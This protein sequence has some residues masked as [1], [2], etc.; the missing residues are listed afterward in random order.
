[1]F[2]LILY[3][4][5]FFATG[6]GWKP[7]PDQPPPSPRTPATAARTFVLVVLLALAGGWVLAP[8]RAGALPLLSHHGRWLTDP[9]GRVVILHGLQVDRFEPRAPIEFIDMSPANVRFLGAMGFNVARVSLAYAGYAPKPGQFD[10]D[11]LNSYLRFDRLLAGAGVY[12]LVDMMQGEYSAAVGGWGF[13]DW[14][15]ETSGLPN[16][17]DPFP[18]GYTDNPAE[19][20]AW[21]NFWADAPGPGGRGLQEQYAGGLHRLALAFASSPG[22]LGLEILNEPWPGTRWPSCASPTGC[23]AGGFD[24]TSFS[25]FYRRMIPAIRSGDPAHLIAYEP[26]LLF[27]FGAATQLADLT[28]PNLLFAFH[29]YCLPLAYGLPDPGGDCGQLEQ[30][31]LYNAEQR[32]SAT[33]DALLMDEWG[34]TTDPTVVNRLGAAADQHM[35]SWSAWAYEDCCHSPAAVV[36]D[37]TKPPTAPGNLNLPVLRLLVRPYPKLIAGTPTAWSYAPDSRVFTLSYSTQRVAGGHFPAQADTEVELPALHYPTGYDV[38]VSGARVASAPDANLLRLLNQ[39]GAA[40]V[41]LT[42]TPARHHAGAPGPFAWP[43]QA[44]VPPADCPP[45]ARLVVHLRYRRPS[46]RLTRVLVYIDGHRSAVGDAVP[47]RRIPLP[48]GLADGTSVRLVA[49]TTGGRQLVTTR[50]LRGCRLTRPVWLV[51]AGA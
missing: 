1:V 41:T 11:Y 42:V 12:D 2:D 45:Q 21:D 17:Q 19:Q 51:P 43:A 15:T 10:T 47:L 31:V 48:A 33:G 30:T 28:D 50:R 13:P 35:V 7:S 27:D 18:R 49:R 4:I 26:N 37:A 29:D 8:A 3:A 6:P 14:M 39:P 34:N 16:N 46:P 24:Q 20:A 36:K 25:D 5:P 9:Q 32:T 40:T 22:L 23:P 44:A 38:R